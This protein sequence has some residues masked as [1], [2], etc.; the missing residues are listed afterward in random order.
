MPT[1]WRTQTTEPA[2]KSGP[3]DDPNTFRNVGIVPTLRSVIDRAFRINTERRY[4]PHCSRHGFRQA[5]SPE[6]AILR[7]MHSTRTRNAPVGLLDI[8]GAY[9]SVPLQELIAMVRER[10]DPNL[11]NMLTVLL[12]PTR[13]PISLTLVLY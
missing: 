12:S 13:D 5:V 9:P 4:T 1:P 11:V 2:Y 3:T 10:I 6:H 8:K 7:V